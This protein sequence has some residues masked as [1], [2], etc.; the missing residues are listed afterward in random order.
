[1]VIISYEYIILQEFIQQLKTILDNSQIILESNNKLPYETDWRDVYH[2]ISLAVLL[3]NSVEQVI[4][5]IKICNTF[6]VKITTQGGNTS[7]CGGAT[8]TTNNTHVIVNLQRMNK[9]ISVNVANSSVILEAGCTLLQLNQ[10]LEQMGL[11][12]PL[13]I[14]SEGNCQIGGNIATNAGGVNV[15][16]Y[17]M[18]RNLVLGLEVITSKGEVINQI[19]YLYKDNTNFDIKQLF[20][21]SE[22]TLGIITKAVL[23]L[24]P[25]PNSSITIYLS[26]DN[27]KQALLLKTVLLNYG[28]NIS[29]FEIISKYTLEVYNNVFKDL[30]QLPTDNWYLLI[31][32]ESFNDGVENQLYDILSSYDDCIIATTKK[33]CDYFWGIRDKIPLAEKLSKPAIKFDIALPLNN[34]QLFLN[35]VEHELKSFHDNIAIIVFG[36]LGD[37]NLHFNLQ[38]EDIDLLAKLKQEITHLIYNILIKLNGSISAEHGIG[39]AKKY[40]YHKYE[41]PTSFEYKK[42]IKN[43][44]DPENI[45]NPGVIY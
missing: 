35:Q 14:A 2:G 8:P 43:M 33:D 37:G 36:H 15:V 11:F 44:F 19:K 17:G 26:V 45:F 16:K 24:Y 31:E 29:V 32:V 28:I 40:W 41:D 7:T 20:I 6:N 21:G 18:M 42:L 39:I 4:N 3:P 1:M 9:I 34:I 25:K 13:R 22:G 10:Y 27:I 12:F 23:K 30:R 5:I 38:F